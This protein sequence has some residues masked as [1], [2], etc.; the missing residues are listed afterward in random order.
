MPVSSSETPHLVDGH[1][2]L[3]RASAA[4]AQGVG[5]QP[6]VQVFGGDALFADVPVQQIAEVEVSSAHVVEEKV[7]VLQT[8]FGEVAW[9]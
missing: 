1:A 2:V 3:C 7:R 4:Y 9:L 6:M 5:H 8:L